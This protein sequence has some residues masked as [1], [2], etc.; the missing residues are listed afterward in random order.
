MSETI[1]M[2]VRMRYSITRSRADKINVGVKPNVGDT[3]KLCS[4]RVIG[5]VWGKNEGYAATT[6]P[7]GAQRPR[8]R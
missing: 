1:S 6:V 8:I 7:L 4:G 3:A 2:I 5:I